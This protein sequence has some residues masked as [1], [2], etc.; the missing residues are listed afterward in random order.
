MPRLYYF[1]ENR[2]PA[3]A[4]RLR[5]FNNT[6]II[7]RLLSRRL[8]FKLIKNKS[9][10]SCFSRRFTLCVRH[11]RWKKKE[12]YIIIYILL[13]IWIRDLIVFYALNLFYFFQFRSP[14]LFQSS[15]RDAYTS[16][17]AVYYHRDFCIQSACRVRGP[18]LCIYIPI[19]LIF[20]TSEK[21]AF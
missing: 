15:A 12:I 10:S 19:K 14:I 20:S 8:W 3:L 13:R 7:R 6:R 18:C 2:S 17:A 16:S 9:S 11:E 21:N 5:R 1:V 4:S